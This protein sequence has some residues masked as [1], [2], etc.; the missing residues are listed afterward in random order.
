[1]TKKF[2]RNTLDEIYNKGNVELADKSYAP[3]FVLHDPVMPAL[4][5]GP[6]AVKQYAR[7]M[8]AALPDLKLDVE[9]IICEGN[10]AAVR[11]TAHGTQRGK[12][13]GIAPTG[14][15]GT[16]TGLD[17]FRLEND[18]IVEAWV[19]WDVISMLQNIGIELP[20]TIEHVA[21]V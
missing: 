15:F 2:I 11:F 6:E 8:R 14:K 9:D 17:F 3:T 7:T 21:H 19:N 10:L 16:V 12:F 13:L 1:M 20:I 5:V 4:P 18:R